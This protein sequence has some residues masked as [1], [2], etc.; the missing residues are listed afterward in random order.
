MREQKPYI[1]L[2]KDKDSGMYKIQ[3]FIVL[4]NHKLTS[5]TMVDEGLKEKVRLNGSRMQCRTFDIHIENG[6]PGQVPEYCESE[7]FVRDNGI[8]CVWVRVIK[9]EGGSNDPGGVANYEDPDGD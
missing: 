4:K 5:T 9:K 6:T 2:F 8:D 7:Y 1:H 3:A